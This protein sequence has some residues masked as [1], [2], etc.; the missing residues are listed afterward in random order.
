MWRLRNVGSYKLVYNGGL[1]S[2]VNFAKPYNRVS[3]SGNTLDYRTSFIGAAAKGSGLKYQTLK[4]QADPK[5][6]TTT[7]DNRAIQ[8]A[9]LD[10]ALISQDLQRQAYNP[11]SAEIQSNP[12]TNNPFNT[13]EQASNSYHQ[14]SNADFRNPLMNNFFSPPR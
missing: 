8:L 3:N 9:E 2:S 13:Q 14:G 11:F 12:N 7:I 1:R 6:T 4:E 5:L 10:K